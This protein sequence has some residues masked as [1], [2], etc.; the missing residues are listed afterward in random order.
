MTLKEE[1]LYLSLL[2]DASGSGI[3]SCNDSPSSSEGVTAIKFSD[4]EKTFYLSI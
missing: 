3:V 2:D 1:R 4:K